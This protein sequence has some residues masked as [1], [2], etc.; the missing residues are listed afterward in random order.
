MPISPRFGIDY[1]LGTEVPDVDG[2]ILKIVNALESLGAQYGMGT[3]A[4]LPTSTPG[5]PGKVGRFYIVTSGTGLGQLHFDFGTGWIYLNP[6]QT[7]ADG[8]VTVAKLAATL[9]GIG[10]KIPAGEITSS[11][12][13]DG[14]IVA[15]DIANALKPSAGA[16]A[17]TE[18]LRA[19]GTA[20]GTALAGNA[21]AAQVVTAVYSASRANG[22]T[23]SITAPT[24]G[25]YILEFGAGVFNESGQGASGFLANN[26]DSVI[27]KY[28][29]VGGN[30]GTALTI[31]TLTA[32]EVVTITATVANSFDHCWAKLTR[33][34]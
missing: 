24:A 11:H 23:Y 3:L 5:S 27:V 32:S 2:D 1:P 14:T 22:Q 15:G 17:S 31:V 30:G 28:H 21:A 16:G 26:K 20:A 7:P 10:A 12:I 13:V 4:N 18:A 6:D 8:S 25:T 9:T 19:L 29:T 33:I 34:S